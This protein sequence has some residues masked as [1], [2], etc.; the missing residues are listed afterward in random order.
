MS[1]KRKTYSADFKAKLVLE[2]L[3]GEKT[4]NEVAS[5]Y[6]VL[7]KSLIDWRKQ[8]IANMSLAFDKSAVVKEYK[9]QIC[10]L[11]KQKDAASKKLGEVIIERDWAMGKLKSLD[12]STR[13]E[14]VDSE[15]VQATTESKNP[16]LENRS[17]RAPLS[18]NRQLELLSISKCGYYYEPVVPFSSKEDK[19]LLDTIDK[20]HTKHPYY[21]TR[22]VEK[23]LKR[24][25][26][27]VGRKLIRTAFNFMG[28]KAHY[29]APKTTVANRE[30]KKYPYLLNEFKNDKNQVVIEKPNQVW[31]GDITYI[32]L[33]HGFAYL[34]AIIDWHT[35]K[36]LGWKLS[37]TMDVHLTTSVLNEAIFKYG[38]PEIF[39]SDQGSQYTAK[40]HIEILTQN[41]ISISMDAKGRS[42]DNIV[43]ERFWRSL[44]YEDVYPS[45]Y[46]TIKEAKDGIAKY[47]NIYNSERLHSSLD[48]QTPDEVYYKQT[49]NKSYDAKKML[50]EVA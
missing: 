11:E 18:L 30:H 37:N 40:E 38:K 2:V 42:I 43:I 50:L 22:R 45:S 1:K 19:R 3:E 8:F 16:S 28:I 17:N 47:M 10:E 4:I 33:E 25:G 21:G 5:Q 15:G 35:K 13:R 7:P 9:E 32:K 20:I 41:E 6:D 36:I 23:L 12:L 26:F 29:P 46:S 24:L 49:N 31:S 44:K 14:M 39:N 27:S 34:A 48:Y